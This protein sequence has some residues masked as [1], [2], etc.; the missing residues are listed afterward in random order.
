MN[1]TC[2]PD[3]ESNPAL[4]HV[5]EEAEHDAELDD[6]EFLAEY[7]PDSMYSDN[8]D[9]PPDILKWLFERKK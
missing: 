6:E 9:D 7:D 1:Q 8:K 5:I 4:M 3:P 2:N